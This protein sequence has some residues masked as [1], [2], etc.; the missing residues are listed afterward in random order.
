MA[1]QRDVAKNATVASVLN[2][3]AAAI[4]AMVADITALDAAIDTLIAKMNSDGG[5]TDVDY[6][7]AAAMTSTALDGD[8]VV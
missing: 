2:D 8:T 6:A 3:H 7:G 4:T 1:V 5:I